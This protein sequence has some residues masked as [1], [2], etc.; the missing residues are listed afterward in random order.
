MID[1]ELVEH[2]AEISK[3]SFMED[4]IEAF[5]GKL[6]EILEYVDKLN[7]LELDGVEPTYQVN[8]HI[9][10]FREDRVEEGLSRE[11]VLKNAP[12]EQYGY[13]KILRI[14]E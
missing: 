6:G 10:P 14:V 8:E 5:T 11:E 2:M 12:E 3:L 1:K 7:E 13:F 4:E 9:Q